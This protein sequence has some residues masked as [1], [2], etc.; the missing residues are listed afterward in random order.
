VDLESGL[1]AA[2]SAYIKLWNILSNIV[3]HR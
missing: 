2:Y 3:L 1:Q